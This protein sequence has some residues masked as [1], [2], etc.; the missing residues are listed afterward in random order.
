VGHAEPSTAA[1]VAAL[2][3]DPERCAEVAKLRYVS[4][5]QPGL[6]RVRKG[7]GFTYRDA[8]GVTVVD[9]ELR[10]RIRSIAIPPAW[11]KVWIAT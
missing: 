8:D 3:D 2:Y 7:K 4:P 1:L 11:Q 10:D 9:V 6:T 5:D